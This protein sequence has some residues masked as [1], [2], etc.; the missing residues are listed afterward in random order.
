MDKFSR[1]VSLALLVSAPLSAPVFADGEDLDV[2]VSVVEADDTVEDAVN[3]I[4]LPEEAS[5]TAREAA[6]LGLSTANAARQRG[7]EETGEEPEGSGEMQAAAGGVAEQASE[8]AREAVKNA[9][10]AA[11]DAA[12]NASEAA[13]EALNNALSGGAE[14]NVPEDVLD[15][16]PE[17]VRDHLPLDPDS[18]VD[19]ATDNIPDDL[20]GNV[21]GS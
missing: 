5:D 9:E 15:N 14:E 10:G 20:P 19:D 8:R 6:A 4:E 2:T 3:V 16:I 13:E 17:D 21:P 18:A 11:R 1:T 7:E 12:S